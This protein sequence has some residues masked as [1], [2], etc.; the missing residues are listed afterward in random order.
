MGSTNFPFNPLPF[1]ASPHDFAGDNNLGIYQNEAT[2]RYVPGTRFTRW[3]G[4]VFKYGKSL[5]TALAPGLGAFNDS[6]IVNIATSATI[7][8]GDRSSVI[9]ADATA[10][11]AADGV[12]VD[13]ELVGG[14]WVTGHAGVTVQQ[15]LIVDTDGIGVTGV[16]GNITVFFDGPISD[17]A[18]TPFTEVTLNPYRYLSIP[19][20]DANYKSVM[21]VP[22]APT[23]G[24]YYCWIQ[25]WGPCWMRPGGGDTSPGDTANDRTAVFVGD[26]SVNFV[27]D[28]TLE[29]GY[30]VA[31]FCIDVTTNG[32]SALPLIMLQISI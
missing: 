31:G 15:R 25:S 19:T 28:T 3:D 13:K 22:A 17:A 9:V 16:G 12:L 23:T 7:A 27:N 2:Q 14:H 32:T 26:G 8:V 21:G 29:N 11:V 10:G 18:T 4:S 5:T 1:H 30:Q 24:T 6:A 20:V